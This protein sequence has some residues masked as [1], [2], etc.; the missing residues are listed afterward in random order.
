M[1][2]RK[3]TIRSDTSVRNLFK[4]FWTTHQNT[5]KHL[6]NYLLA[7]ILPM[8]F[9]MAA[10]PVFSIYLPPEQYAVIGYYASFTTLF[11][12]LIM[13]YLTHYYMRTYYELEEEQRKHLYQT[14]AQLLVSLS[15]GFMIAGVV[16][17]AV[18]NYFFNVKTAM[19]VWPYCLLALLPPYLGGLFQLR[20]VQYKMDRQ[21][22]RYLLWSSGSGIMMIVVSLLLVVSGG[23]RWAK[24]WEWF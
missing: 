23:G 12:P 5:F 16:A 18:Y 6:N 2:Q 8:L 21:S 3:K 22:T 4:A 24:C 9:N 11:T 15:F 1:I 13:F 7:S 10:N 14:M 20:L 17:V 19:P